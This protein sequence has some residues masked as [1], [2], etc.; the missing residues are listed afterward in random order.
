MSLS[1]QDMKYL[2]NGK[3]I[4]EEALIAIAASKGDDFE[5]WC[6]DVMDGTGIGE[7]HNPSSGVCN[8][9]FVKSRVRN[10]GSMMN[11]PFGCQF[12]EDYSRLTNTGVA[13]LIRRFFPAKCDEKG[14]SAVIVA[15]WEFERENNTKKHATETGFEP[16]RPKPKH[17]VISSASP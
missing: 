6:I 5:K 7:P 4:T 1:N 2:A 10:V 9:V 17:I 3:F 13:D 8:N 12:R 16:A 14:S 11:T 15:R